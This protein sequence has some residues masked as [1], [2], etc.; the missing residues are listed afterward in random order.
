MDTG[1]NDKQFTLFLKLLYKNLQ[2]IRKEENPQTK[3]RKIDELLY[4][5]QQSIK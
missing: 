5:I 2:A 1:M 4:D 3:D